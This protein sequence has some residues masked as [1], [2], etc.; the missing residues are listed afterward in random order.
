MYITLDILQ[1]RGA[2]Q[3]ALDFFAKHY[4]N[5]LEMKYAIEKGH[6]PETFLHWGYENLDPNEEEVAAYW[7]KID[8]VKSQ[9]VWE[10]ARVHN[11]TLIRGSHDIDDSERVY[12][13][14]NVKNSVYISTSD[15]V[16][17]SQYVGNTNFAERAKYVLN[18][19]NITDST[20]V[21]ESNYI[22]NSEGIYR[23]NNVVDSIGIWHG[24]NITNC[25][26]CANCLDLEKSLFCQGQEGGKFLLFNKQID[27][28]RFDMIYKQFIKFKPTITTTGDWTQVSYG[29]LPKV[30]VDYRAHLAKVPDSFWDW[31]KTLPGYDPKIVYSLTF[32]SRFL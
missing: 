1:Q 30:V 24:T 11:S 8:V 26:F 9:G 14:N 16:E 7:N 20:E 27:E 13:S 21:A 19:T 18:C 29:D 17:D 6:L 23:S 25:G 32:D 12:K 2:C 31:V 28:R 3:E 22:V 15:Y 5:G 4:P 10:S